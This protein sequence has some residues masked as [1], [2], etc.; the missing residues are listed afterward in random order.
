VY[1]V[2]GGRVA[3]AGAGLDGINGLPAAVQK[4]VGG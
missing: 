4:A 3:Y 1:V 2:K